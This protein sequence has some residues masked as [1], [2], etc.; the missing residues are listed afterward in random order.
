M[1]VTAARGSQ[2]LILPGLDSLSH[3][4]L[5][6]S[7]R[8]HVRIF[9]FPG[10]TNR[11]SLTEVTFQSHFWRCPSLAVDTLKLINAAICGGNKQACDLALSN[12][13][14]TP[15]CSFFLFLYTLIHR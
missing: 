13:N 11:C 8:I 14:H 7:L 10:P 9:C 2:A 15:N 4:A 1:Y 12:T 3:F 6:Q 5:A